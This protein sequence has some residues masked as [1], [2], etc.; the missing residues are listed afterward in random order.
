MVFN[1][2]IR[3]PI[4]D[5]L[6][7]LHPLSP[8]EAPRPSRWGVGELITDVH[9]YLQL[10]GINIRFAMKKIDQLY[11]NL[12][13]VF[14][15]GKNAFYVSNPTFSQCKWANGEFYTIGP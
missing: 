14:S 9:A 5:A 11:F 12:C 6:R 3:P 13:F 8:E 10:F 7:R 2:R 15:K 4:L 1:V